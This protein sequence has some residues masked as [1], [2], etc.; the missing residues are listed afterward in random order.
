MFFWF[1]LA[2]LV[3]FPLLK[4]ASGND[5]SSPFLG[6]LAV[7]A[8]YPLGIFL[9]RGIAGVALRRKTVAL[10]SV[11]AASGIFASMTCPDD[12]RVMMLA[13]LGMIVVAAM[14]IGR[15][16]TIEQSQFKLYLLGL[17]VVIA[18]SLL[19]LAPFWSELLHRADQARVEAAESL[20]SYFSTLGYSQ[21]V[22]ETTM[23]RF[24]SM[25]RWVT[26][27]MPVAT[28]MNLVTQYSI[29]FLWFL[30][31]GVPDG[32]IVGRLRPFNL[33]KMPFALTP[34]VI[35]TI[36]VKL[37]GGEIFALV[38]D[39]VL[40]ALSVF[41]CVTGLSLTEHFLSRIRLPLFSRIL[42]YVML[43]FSGLIGYLAVVMLGLIDSYADWRKTSEGSE[44]LKKI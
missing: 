26:R 43:T 11:A 5:P 22:I 18:G 34:V 10:V 2:A 21:D 38:A 8:A 7:A 35:V 20:R 42:F 1:V 16:A 31:R 25:A 44:D 30:W 27:L 17:A 41:Y 13:N 14:V 32:A 23:S 6:I 37:I 15:R 9:Y 28:V 40:A 36:L 4:Y 19:M 29:G 33:W 12:Q 39:N 3:L 24:D